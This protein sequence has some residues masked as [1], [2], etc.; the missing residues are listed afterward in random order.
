MD[1]LTNDKRWITEALDEARLSGIDVPVGCV[2]LRNNEIIARGHN[3]RESAQDPTNHA[4]IIAIRQAAKSLGSWRLEGCTVYTTLEPCPMCAE[5]LIQARVERVVF[6]A[7]DPAS[8]A[9]GTVFN[10][11]QKGRIYPIP[12]LM[13]GVLED[14]C[15]QMIVD[16]F[17]QRPKAFKT[18]DLK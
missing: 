11:F 12:D 7:Y 6:G 17:R 14:E 8:G 5:A 18:L 15:K 13:G 2:I 10:L 16:F 4:E 3:E 9:C 1:S